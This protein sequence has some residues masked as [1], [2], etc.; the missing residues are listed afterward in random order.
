MSRRIHLPFLSFCPRTLP[1]VLLCVSLL[2]AMIP[3]GYMPAP[4]AAQPGTLS[5]T[6]CI[7]GL[8]A[9]IVKKLALEQSPSQAES[10]MLDCAFGFVASQSVLPVAVISFIAEVLAS[11]QPVERRA[12]IR[13][14]HWTVRGPPL[15]SRAPPILYL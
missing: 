6:L 13:A 11:A 12:A 8:P 10:H 9:G 3:A 5:M 4:A 7:R 1:W 14:F 2:R 15:G